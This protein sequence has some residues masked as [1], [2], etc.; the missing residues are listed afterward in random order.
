METRWFHAPQVPRFTTIVKNCYGTN[1]GNQETCK[2]SGSAY[3]RFM[4]DIS[5]K[6]KLRAKVSEKTEPGTPARVLKLLE[7]AEDIFLAKGYYAA[8]M[9]DVAKAAG[10]SKKT[11]YMII[12]SKAELFAALLAHHH[13]L[14]SFPTPEPDWTVHDILTAHLLCLG[15]FL[16]SP[17]QIAILRLIMAEYTHSPDLGRTFLRNRVHKAKTKLEDCLAEI[18]QKYNCHDSDPKEMAAMLFGMAL[19]EFHLSVL[20]GYRA[21]PTRQ[22]L[23]KRVHQAV[24]IFV[25]GCCASMSVAGCS[26]Q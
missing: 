21:A 5:A 12:E 18:A 23:E 15:R 10:M 13:S 20:I 22:T 3:A 14:L 6:T 19:G 9:N 8:T 17:G 26:S 7:A 4:A 24:D 16:L 2:F 1:F 11:V 25:A